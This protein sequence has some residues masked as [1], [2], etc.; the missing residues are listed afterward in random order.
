MARFDK[1]RAKSTK[2][3]APVTA[4][5][6]RET[7]SPAIEDTMFF[8]RLRRHAKWMFVLLALVFALGFVGFG[9]GAGGVGVGDIFRGSGGGGSS[10]SDAREKTEEQPN[11]AEAWQDLATA[12]QADGDLAGALEA[13]ARVVELLPEDPNPL[14]ELA[15]LNFAVAAEKQQELQ[16][17]QGAAALIGAGHNFPRPTV[18]GVQIGGDAVGRAV[19]ATVAEQITEVSIEAQTALGDAIAAYEQLAAL[20]PNDPSVQLELAQAAVQA[21]DLGTA[22]TAYERFLVLA[23][24]DPSTADVKRQLDQLRAATAG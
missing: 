13:Q 18:G 2:P 9:V 22:I 24:D 19:N 16:L 6:R 10:V 8:P 4:R 14:R 21:G 17:L 20:Q 7:M 15:A 5:P 12:L 3:N 11:D 23:P 1:S